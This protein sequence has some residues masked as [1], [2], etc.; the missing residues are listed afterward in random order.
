[1]EPY[2][3]FQAKLLRSPLIPALTLVLIF[4][5]GFV[6]LLL[7]SPPKP[8]GLDTPVDE[9]SA[10]RAF[11]HIKH[12]AQKPHMSGSAEIE[13]VCSYIVNHLEELGIEVDIQS[14]TVYNYFTI[15]SFANITNIA[16]R[17]KG[18]NSSKAIL[19]VGHYDTQPHTPGAADNGLAVASMLETATIL[20]NHYSLENDIIFL[21]TDAE[22]IEMLGA[23]AFAKEHPWMKEVGLVINLEARG[24]KGTVLA[25]EVNPQNGWIIPE[26]VKGAHRPFAGSMMYEV[27]KLM[28][29]YSDFSVFK[30]R[31]FSGINL[32]LVEGFVN[33][34]SPTDTP[35][36][37]SLASLQHMGGYVVSLANHFGNIS[38]LETKANDLVY[39]NVIAHLM[40]YFPA[41]WNVWIFIAIVLLFINFLILAFARKR[42]SLP[43]VLLSFVYN[44]FVFGIIIGA[45]WGVNAL[46]KIAY[47]H[48][49]VFNAS[50]FYNVE[51]YFYAY[52]AL[53][54]GLFSL[55]YSFFLNKVGAISSI[56]AVFLLFI[57]VSLLLLISLPTASYITF[58]PLLFG[59][60]VLNV[61]LF[62]DIDK[63]TNSPVYHAVLFI[64][65]APAILVISPYIYLLFCTF[66]LSIPFAGVAFFMILLLFSLPL[67]EEAL[68]R[69][70]SLLP[71]LFILVSVL[72]FVIAHTQSKPS[73]DRPLQ[74]NLMYAALNSQEKALWI[75]LNLKTDDWNSQFFNEYKIDG[76]TEIY[77]W[78]HKTTLK[79]K[80]E[81]ISFDKPL[82]D[83]I[84]HSSTDSSRVLEF[85]LKSE[86]NPVMI[87]FIIPINSIITDI[88]INSKGLDILNVSTFKRLSNYYFRLINPSSHGDTIRLEY[89]GKD[90][91]SIRLIEKVL[92]I[93]DFDYINPMP[94]HIIPHTG[95]ESYVTLVVSEME[96]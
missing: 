94:A 63:E 31:G 15:P 33:Y 84:S 21:F 91:M 56:A 25:F 5:L 8:R 42:I 81:F 86:I 85:S 14:S 2:N 54:F 76:L 19:F 55:L 80:A 89:K 24:N 26:F 12:I 29:N 27:Y 22:E 87:D 70:W 68:L 52:M 45:V 39:F 72:F 74:S 61:L 49:N 20:K 83:I 73:A 64:G 82:I 32:A 95:F 13:N 44:F 46:V 6:S 71:A 77:P 88:K 53:A 90:P 62:F 30:N 23:E 28:P 93:P 11:V 48:Y 36:N 78:R 16:G 75:S 10:E 43:Q 34:H 41:S 92:G 7:T 60:L 58:V 66:G 18:T 67:L 4:A 69:F 57:I 9:F 1:M 38:L 37:L 65:V 51:N 50:N 17:L 40:V 3:P 35:E 59:L 96:M 47:P 79:N